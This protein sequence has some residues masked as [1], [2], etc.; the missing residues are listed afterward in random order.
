MKKITVLTSLVTFFGVVFICEAF[1]M[2]FVYHSMDFLKTPLSPYATGE[3]WY[4][5]SSGLLLIATSYFILAFLFTKT[6]QEKQ[7]GIRTGSYL[8]IF[9]SICTYSLTIFYTDIGVTTTVR[10]HIHLISAHMHFIFLP[11]A[12][13]VISLNLRGIFWN[14]YKMYSLCFAILLIITG[15]ALV[16]KRFL[17]IDQYSGLIQKIVIFTIIV[18]IIVSAQVHRQLLIQ[19]F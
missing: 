16:F 8:L 4:V 7:T 6:D 1:I 13:I 10:G 12:I 2:Q 15:F 14:K 3:Y 5:V 18:W 11:L 19:K 17:G 9:T